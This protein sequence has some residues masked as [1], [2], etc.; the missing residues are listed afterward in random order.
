[1]EKDK[2]RVMI[3]VVVPQKQ[4]E[5]AGYDIVALSF[6]EAYAK[7]RRMAPVGDL[8]IRLCIEE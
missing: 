2:Q 4:E 1:M 8:R 6:A 3:D 7:L 5:R